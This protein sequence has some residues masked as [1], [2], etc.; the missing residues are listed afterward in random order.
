[1]LKKSFTKYLFEKVLLIASIIILLFTSISFASNATSNLGYDSRWVKVDNEWKV[2][3]ADG[4]YLSNCWF[5]DTVQS[6]WYRIGAINGE[7][8]TGTTG[9]YSSNDASSMVAGL[10]TE[11]DTNKS[12][13][14][15][16]TSSLT[17]GALI[18]KNGYYTINGKSVYLEFEQND[19]NTKGSITVGL[20]DLRTVLAKSNEVLMPKAGSG[21]SGGGGSDSGGGTAPVKPVA[22]KVKKTI[23]YYLIGSDLEEKDLTASYD[24]YDISRP[25]YPSDVRVL[26]LTGGSRMQYVEKAR[27]ASKDENLKEMFVVNW[28]KNQIWEVRK[29]IKCIEENF[30]TESMTDPNTLLKFLNYAKTYYPSDEYNIILS[31][32]GGG[33]Y[34]GLGRDKRENIKKT[35]SLSLIEIKSTF[36]KSGLKFGFIGFDA[37]LMSCIEYLYGLSDYA[38][39]YI[40]SADIERGSWDY[41]AFEALSK[42][43]NI[44][45]ENLLKGIIDKYIGKKVCETNILALFNLKNFK[46]DLKPYL[47]TFAKNIYDLSIK[48]FLSIKELVQT[49]SKAIEYG[50]DTNY[51]F[52]DIYDF[53]VKIHNSNLPNNTKSAIGDL[54]DAVNSHIIYISSNR[55][56][57]DQ[58]YYNVGGVSIY[59]PFDCIGELKDNTVL[60]N[61]YKSMSDLYDD[62]FN[63]M[64][65]LIY[66]RM[67]LAL[68]IVN[69]SAI[70]DVNLIK[71][72]DNEVLNLAKK[73][74][75]LTNDEI[76]KIKTNI[77]PD[78]IRYR[79]V[80]DN[81]NYAF[82][83]SGRPG[84]LLFSY[85]KY[86][87][88]YLN[89]IYTVPITYND[90]GKALTLG[91]VIVPH[92]EVEEPDKIVWN[93]APREGYWFTMSDN[94]EEILVSFYPTELEI[95][96]GDQISENYLFDKEITGYIP[97]ILK[98]KD[99][100]GNTNEYNIFI[101]AKF[102]EMNNN[103]KILGYCD[104]NLVDK[105]EPSKILRD[106]NDGD[107]V[108]PIYNFE[109]VKDNQEIVDTGNEM[110]VKSLK[111]KR[112]QIDDES[113]YYEYNVL[114]AFNQKTAL[115]FGDVVFKDASKN[116][117]FAMQEYETWY[118]YTYSAEN[119]SISMLSEVAGHQEN[120]SVLVNSVPSGTSIYYDFTEG[121]K[122]FSD[123]IINYFRQRD[124]DNIATSSIVMKQHLKEKPEPHYLLIMDA[125]KNIG[126]VNSTFSKMFVVYPSDD[127]MYLFDV[128]LWSTGLETIYHKNKML[129][130]L[131][132]MIKG[133][134]DEPMPD[135]TINIRPLEINSNNNSLNEIN[136][137]LA[138]VATASELT[139]EVAT[140]SDID[141]T[142][143][144]T[145]SEPTTKETTVESEE[146]TIETAESTSETIET[147]TETISESKESTSEIVETTSEAVESTSETIE[148]ITET[149]EST[150]EIETSSETVE[151]TSDENVET[152]CENVETTTETISESEESTSEIVETTSETVEMTSE[153]IEEPM[154]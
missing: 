96:N 105:C 38:D 134:Y 98:T 25:D 35:S 86:L 88:A 91:H 21:G 103:A 142:E 71:K 67:A 2:K 119:N 101:Y 39:Y 52:V 84:E 112:G 78:L 20:S 79:L 64:L 129:N 125:K 34:G 85:D 150:N 40:G 92:I 27:K 32:H 80:N 33:S 121:E 76:N 65:K 6:K 143:N 137:E 10:W 136:E 61:F 140:K 132:T 54:W 100:D 75:G 109:E 15:D 74:V 13:F 37:C 87:N 118:D 57:N 4:S 58:G 124:F 28:D 135:I 97:A 43:P 122:E 148:T 117:N 23:L 81:P 107:T 83:R 8:M 139:L 116:I 94:K 60:E 127:G 93:I 12:Y 111:I 46:Q 44:S 154:T 149:A 45:N 19:A 69:S 147:T 26:T 5:F 123:E 63:T 3:N 17:Y 114:D 53:M 50:I 31:D 89:E 55:P 7:L 24:L 133:K 152:T 48:D 56:V 16:N 18:D 68:K 49:R 29:G 70:S 66:I 144:E 73:K 95:V 131:A 128:A 99:D 130:Y 138:S 14:F 151:V 126:G 77:Y 106:F 145:T 115:T 47:S 59:F 82:E 110:N 90:D 141:E 104:F 153:I 30:G 22:P 108:K 113:I 62:D 102:E 1:M 9:F 72:L 146:P 120:I 41:K 51:D 11:R 36:D 42:T